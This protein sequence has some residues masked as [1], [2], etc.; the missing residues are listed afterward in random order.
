MNKHVATYLNIKKRKD[1]V[2]VH[3]YG[4]SMVLEDQCFV[5]HSPLNQNSLFYLYNN[6]LCSRKCCDIYKG[7]RRAN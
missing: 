6:V 5:C 1:M 7:W 2:V 4:Y 3:E